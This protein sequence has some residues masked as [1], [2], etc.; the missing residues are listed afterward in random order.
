MI[1]YP[2]HDFSVCPKKLVN[3]GGRGVPI[4]SRLMCNYLSL[5]HHVRNY[6]AGRTIFFPFFLES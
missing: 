3:L 6:S 5:S 4:I 1:V 2:R